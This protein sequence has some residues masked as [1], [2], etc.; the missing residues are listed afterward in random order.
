MSLD[1]RGIDPRRL[2]PQSLEDRLLGWLGRFGGALLL[3]STVAIWAS[4]VSWSVF[5][6]SLTHTTAVAARN[7]AGPVGAIISDLLFQTL[8]FAAV[9]A[10]RAPFV[11]WLVLVSYERVDGG[12]S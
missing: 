5:D 11:L 1:T 12:G 6:P 4:L 7:F 3:A 9:V 10:L 2:L 8:G